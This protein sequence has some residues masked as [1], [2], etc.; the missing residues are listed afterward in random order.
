MKTYTDAFSTKATPQTE[1]IPGREAEMVPNSA[2]GVVFALDD[3]KRLDRFIVLGSDAPTY[4][5]GAQKLTKENATCVLRCIKADGPRT[6]KAIVEV[7]DQGR[8][9]KNDPALFALA[10]CAKLGDDATRKLA[11]AAMNKVVRIGTHLF[12]FAQATEAFGG[13]GRGQKR[14]FTNWYTDRQLDSLAVQL[15]KYQQRDGWSHRD[16]LRLCKPS[17]HARGSQLDHMLAWAVGK[18][19]V[20][21]SSIVGLDDAVRKNYGHPLI[22]AFEEAKTA[23]AK[24]TIELIT[25]HNLPRECVMST[26]LQDP[27]VWEAL[28]MA[29]KGMPMTAMVRNLG[30]MTSVGLL[31]P[32]SEASR[33]VQERLEDEQA[34][35]RARVHPLSLLVALKTYSSGAGVKGSLT[36]SPVSQV[37]DA[38]DAAFYASFKTVVPTGKRIMLALDVS[39]SMGWNNIAGMPITPRDASA[40]MAMVTA[41]VEKQT[42]VVGFASSRN[43]HG[44]D[45][46]STILTMLD[47]SPRKR[48]DDN[49]R[50]VSGLP[51]GGTDCALPWIYAREN[52]IAVDA[53]VTYTDNETWAGTIQP[54]QAMDQYAQE[55]G[56][57]PKAVVVG[58][59]STGFTIADPSRADNLDVVGFDSAAPAV[60][61]DFIAG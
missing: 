40:A 45:G 1:A 7:S 10:M 38:L 35:Y 41:A 15:V 12:H 43:A 58:M 25:E 57:A 44:W 52:K 56:I 60:M 22:A 51:F 18:S 50:K 47:I 53:V 26:H 17:G 6:V 13:W 36:W 9:P 61:S 21:E 8:A 29:G 2:G 34:L 42:F 49:I 23:D 5:A 4:Y 48:L 37:T 19:H 16:I 3:W 11:W 39:G 30:K 54:V 20:V 27:R 59:T 33:F 14:A 46:G 31:K 24:R 55:M 32:L 28:L